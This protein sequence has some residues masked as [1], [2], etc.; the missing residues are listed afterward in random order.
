M[1]L[2]A[3][4]FLAPGK[5]K[6]KSV[7]AEPAGSLTVKPSTPA[8]SGALQYVVRGVNDDVSGDDAATA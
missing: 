7:E 6:V 4:L 8:K 3:K 1:D 5:R 2:E